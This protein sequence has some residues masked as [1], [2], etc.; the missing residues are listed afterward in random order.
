L[1]DRKLEL[2][3]ILGGRCN[4]CGYN[5]CLWALDFHHKEECISRVIHSSSKEKALKEAKKCIILCANCHRELHYKE[6]S[7]E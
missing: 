3:N 5:I 6:R 7:L 2:I 4:L 1:R